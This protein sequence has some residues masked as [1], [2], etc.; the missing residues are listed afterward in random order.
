M[1]GQPVV[2][3]QLSNLELQA[4]RDVVPLQYRLRIRLRAQY[5]TNLYLT[6]IQYL[7]PRRGFLRKHEVSVTET[8]QRVLTST[9]MMPALLLRICRK[10]IWSSF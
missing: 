1:P 10:Y 2:D 7:F 3:L 4:L 5:Y 8:D 9:M 6:G